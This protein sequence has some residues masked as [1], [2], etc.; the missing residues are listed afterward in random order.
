MC[1]VGPPPEKSAPYGPLEPE[2]FY[3]LLSAYMLS[4]YLTSAGWTFWN[5]KSEVKDPRWSFFDAQDRGWF[6][7]NLS[8]DAWAPLA[9]PCEAKDSFA[10]NIFWCIVVLAL[11]ASCLVGC[12]CF[13]CCCR[14]CV[15]RAQARD[16]LSQFSELLDQE[17]LR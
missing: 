7:A 2:E 4:A 1:P 17:L 9:L 6:P 12:T 10:G 8:E 11:S 15:K 5:F 14:C 3:K 16:D 13:Y